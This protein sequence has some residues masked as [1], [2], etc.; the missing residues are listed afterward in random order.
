MY[1][2]KENKTRLEQQDESE[3]YM[4]SN[5]DYDERVFE[6]KEFDLNEMPPQSVEDNNGVKL[7]VIGKP[8]CFAP[9]T[10]VLMFD[11]SIKKVEDVQVGDQVM[12]DDGQTPRTV[13]KLYHDQDEMFEICPKRGTSYTVNSRHPLVLEIMV[14]NI[15]KV[16][17]L[18]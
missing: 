4:D 9:G 16:I 3:Y 17:S 18:K 13:E 7:V 1:R 12:G 5:Y 6:I 2:K 14:R 11:G 15:R 10:E 8:G